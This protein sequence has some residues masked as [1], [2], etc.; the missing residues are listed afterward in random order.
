MSLIADA[1]LK[2]A[3]DQPTTDELR[4]LI[5]R[6][7]GSAQFRRSAR[8]R[9]F[10]LYIRGR[11]LKPGCPKIHE[12]E[13]GT[14]VFGRSASCD[15]SQD[16]I[17]RVSATELR[18]HIE[19]YFAS[20]GAHGTLV[21]EIPRGGYKPALRSQ[22]PGWIQRVIAYLPNLSYTGN[23]VVFAGTDSDATSAAAE[24]LTSE[25]QLS[26]LQT[27]LAFRSFPTFKCCSKYSGSALLRSTQ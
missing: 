18:K 24:F 25:D 6:V 17:V 27:S 5:D 19:L 10:L 3:L 11:S 7:A 9:D 23:V 12:Q 1:P 14:K 4:A 15:R 2:E 20:E 8:L 16:N 22:R 21:L 13:S 26:R